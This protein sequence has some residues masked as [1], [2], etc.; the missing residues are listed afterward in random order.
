MATDEKVLAHPLTGVLAE[1]ND[2][3][4]QEDLTHLSSQGIL[5]AVSKALY[6]AGDSSLEISAQSAIDEDELQTQTYEAY[7]DA[8]IV[9]SMAIRGLANRLSPDLL[10]L[11]S[12]Q[13]IVRVEQS[14]P[15]RSPDP[16]SE[17]SPRLFVTSFLRRDIGLTGK[18]ISLAT[19][20]S[21]GSVS[22]W[23]N[24]ESYSGLNFGYK[25]KYDQPLL[26]AYNL[27]KHLS[28]NLEIQNDEI[29]HY[30]TTTYYSPPESNEVEMTDTAL[31]PL[32]ALCRDPKNLDYLIMLANTSYPEAYEAFTRKSSL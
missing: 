9:A 8:L 15:D 7:G 32:L 30:L 14:K 5:V 26:T 10:T 27:V 4:N 23:I 12:L 21:S 16:S 31:I 18:E 3:L 25:S 29:H 19:G 28:E 22:Q 24:H 6:S 11:P 17:P 13:D 1:F 20:A 2:I